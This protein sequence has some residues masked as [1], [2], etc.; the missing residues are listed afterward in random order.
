MLGLLFQTAYA[1]IPKFLSPSATSSIPE[2]LKGFY[3]FAILVAGVLAV[4]AIVVGGV[5]YSISGAVDKKS[6]G[7]EIIAGALW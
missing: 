2:F 4:G 1:Q 3:D 7:K 6:E 5:Y